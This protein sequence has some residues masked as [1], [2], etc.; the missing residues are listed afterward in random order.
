[1]KVMFKNVI[2]TAVI[3]QHKVQLFF[4]LEADINLV[5]FYISTNIKKIVNI[6]EIYR[7]QFFFILVPI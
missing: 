4:I 6:H 5:I 2:S 7:V 3:K 1:M